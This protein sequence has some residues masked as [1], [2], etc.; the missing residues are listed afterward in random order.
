MDN[1]SNREIIPDLRK[2]S[3]RWHGWHS[4]RRGLA[5]NLR[6]LGI[7]DDV[8]QRILRHSDISTTQEHYA[9][10]LPKSVRKAMAKLERS[11]KRDS[12][13]ARRV[14]Y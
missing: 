7:S 5:T 11:L 12:Q 3:L 9:K 10:T 8:I 14:S 4:F 1:R 6:E 13:K 2:H